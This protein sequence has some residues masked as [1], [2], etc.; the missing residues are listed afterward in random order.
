MVEPMSR[1]RITNR[2][3]D[4]LKI[5]NL[6]FVY[7]EPEE[8]QK[9][10]ESIIYDKVVSTTRWEDEFSKND[11]IK[12]IRGKFSPIVQC[13]LAYE[14]LVERVLKE[15]QTTPFGRT[16][17]KVLTMIFQ[18]PIKEQEE[19]DITFMGRGQPKKIIGIRL[20]ERILENVQERSF[21]GTYMQVLRCTKHNSQFT[22]TVEQYAVDGRELETQ[23]YLIKCE[24]CKEPSEGTEEWQTIEAPSNL[25]LVNS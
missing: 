19:I 4:K 5:K 14:P 1:S 25:I 13:L 12:C 10:M 18:N 23:D 7:L 6:D 20:I 16:F 2:E 17:Q 9:Q 11:G 24:R 3:F 21:L 22:S 15:P 8:E